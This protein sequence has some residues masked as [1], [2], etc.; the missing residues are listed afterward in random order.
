M[1]QSLQ[2]TMLSLSLKRCLY[3]SVTKVSD[4]PTAS[5]LYT[6]VKQRNVKSTEWACVLVLNTSRYATGDLFLTVRSKHLSSFN[7]SDITTAVTGMLS[8]AGT[9]YVVTHSPYCPSLFLSDFFNS[10][11]IDTVWVK[12]HSRWMRNT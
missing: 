2:C 6:Q 4:C 9:W 5:K 11:Y 3:G 12:L 1:P 8:L 10:I 7:V